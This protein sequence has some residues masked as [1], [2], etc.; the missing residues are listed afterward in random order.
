MAIIVNIDD[1]RFNTTVE[2]LNDRLSNV[3][4]DRDMI[5]YP[6]AERVDWMNEAVIAIAN[7][8]PESQTVTAYVQLETGCKQLLPEGGVKVLRDCDK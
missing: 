8:Q 5:R 6:L 1:T 3:L 7:R 2:D 4:N